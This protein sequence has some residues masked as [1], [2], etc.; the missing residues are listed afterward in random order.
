MQGAQAG[1]EGIRETRQGLAQENV[2]AGFAIQA[3]VSPE[4]MFD[5]AKQKYISHNSSPSERSG[6][7]PSPGGTEFSAR[8]SAIMSS[9]ERDVMAM[10][11]RGEI[12]PEEAAQMIQ[13]LKAEMQGGF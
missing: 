7:E 8:Q 9:F 6:I 3:I 13:D 4:Q 11:E 10:L 1:L 12:K 2:E 5:D